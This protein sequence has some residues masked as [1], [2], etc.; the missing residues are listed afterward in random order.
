MLLDYKQVHLMGI[1][2]VAM[3]ALAQ[4]LTDAG[5]RITGSDVAAE[6]VT[7][8]QLDRIEAEVLPF[9][10]TIPEN[11]E[12][13]VYTAAH[14]GPEHPEVL[15]ARV[16]GIPTYSN[17]AAI[18]ELFD[19][20]QGIAIAGTSGK[21]TTTA[22]VTWILEQSHLEPSYVVGV[23]AIKG[24]EASGAWR[25]DGAHFIAEADEY[26]TDPKAA[27]SD[28]ATGHEARFLSLHPVSI[29]C[30]NLEFEHADVYRDRAHLEE[31]FLSFFEQLDADGTLIVPQGD[32]RL[33]K[34][35][36]SVISDS[37]RKLKTFGKSKNS[38]LRLLSQRI[39]HGV[40]IAE[41]QYQGATFTLKLNVPGEFN[42]LNAMAALLA[43][44]DVGI[45]IS[46]GIDILSR[47]HS[48]KRRFEFIGHSRDHTFHF[49]DDYAHHPQEITATLAA[50]RQWE[51]DR[52]ISLIF[53]P[54]TFTRTQALFDETVQALARADEILLLDIFASAR[55]DDTYD[56]TS[57]DLTS[58][59]KQLDTDITVKRVEDIDEAAELIYRDIDTATDRSPT[60]FMTMGAG[61]VYQTHA[62]LKTLGYDTVNE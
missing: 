27:R 44:H 52:K 9:S 40:N 54:H 10:D 11:T 4:C 45:S 33:L 46:R 17:A 5:I 42:V 29:V 34:M 55:E 21:S 30:T 24:L 43:A 37:D 35:A 31:T 18:G 14:E 36:T 39:E 1:K 28:K 57:D 51:P 22:M 53:Q 59:I 2:G 60:V 19:T 23:G 25:E 38:D 13:L 16:A 6:F 48:T 56:V 12:A 15:A 50:L 49:Y 3:T 32:H 58:A 62:I 8:Q 20:K 26:V 41:I 61:D 7:K 47:F